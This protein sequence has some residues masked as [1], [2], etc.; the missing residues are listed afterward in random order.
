MFMG[1]ATRVLDLSVFLETPCFSSHW[2]GKLS[3]KSS[4][5]WWRWTDLPH[6]LLWQQSRS[7]Q[8]P[9]HDPDLHWCR[10]VHLLCWWWS[11]EGSGC[12]VQSPVNRI[13]SQTSH[14]QHPLLSPVENR[15][16]RFIPTIQNYKMHVYNNSK[17]IIHKEQQSREWDF[18]KRDHTIFPC[19]NPASLS[20]YTGQSNML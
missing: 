3:I 6:P 5:G 18:L 16:N 8:G 2:G 4:F 12:L 15:H 13:R 7:W 1:G 19:I 14:H 9:G 11:R 17:C 10:S 20:D